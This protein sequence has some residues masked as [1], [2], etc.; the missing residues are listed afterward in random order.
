MIKTIFFDMGG[1]VFLQDTDEAYRRFQASGIDTNKYLGAYQQNG[2]FLD[3]E[4]GK[5]SA[6]EFCAKMAAAIGRESISMDEARYCWLGYLA[7]VPEDRLQTIE[8][9]K[10][11]YRV[12]LLS[13]TNPFMMGFTRSHEFTKQGLSIDHYFHHLYLSYEMHVC[14][15]NKEIFIAALEHENILPCEALFIDDSQRNIDAAHA[16][17]MKT[18]YVK[19]N[20]D[21]RQP[22]LSILNEL[23]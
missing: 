18:L 19:T 11:D 23:K 7:S 4:T 20:S 14:K 5:I 12:C 22:L 1:V 17:G 3:V 21:W 2:F 16:L 15:P 10:R 6:D 8:Q 9:L 13:N